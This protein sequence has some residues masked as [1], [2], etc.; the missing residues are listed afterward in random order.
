[1]VRPTVQIVRE[2]VPPGTAGLVLYGKWVIDAKY[3]GGKMEGNVCRN[4][5]ANAKD[6]FEDIGKFI[7]ESLGEE[8]GRNLEVAKDA[9]IDQ[10]CE[11]MKTLLILLESVFSYIYSVKGKESPKEARILEAR[12]EILYKEWILAKMSFTPKFHTLLDHVIKQLQRIAGYAVMGE[13]RIERSHQSRFAHAL[14]L[15]RLRNRSKAMDSQAKLQNMALLQEIKD[16]QHEVATKSN[17]KMKREVSLK[18]EKDTVKRKK[19]EDT[20]QLEI[21]TR[22]DLIDEAEP[23]CDA[24][25]LIKQEMQQ[26]NTN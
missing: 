13:D 7:K 6:I 3:H 26:D 17:W 24:R 4:L 9:K 15:A 23:I 8:Q 11:K 22:N 1:M 14:R 19:R 21:A 10:V 16:I 5:M 12:L 20:Q 18:M 2:Y 25:E